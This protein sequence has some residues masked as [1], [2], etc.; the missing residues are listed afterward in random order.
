[1]KRTILC[2]LS[3]CMVVG[4]VS[5]AGNKK[6]RK[7]PDITKGDK[8]VMPLNKKSEG[9]PGY[10]NLGPTGLTGF[11]VGGDSGSQIIT[12][13]ISPHSPASGKLIRGDIILAG[14]LIYQVL[15]AHTEQ[16]KLMVSDAG[17]LEGILLSGIDEYTRRAYAE[18]LMGFI[19]K[20]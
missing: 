20:S 12:H 13:V 9:W 8:W 18:I 15:L 14:S 11:M 1:M 6:A 10:F 3:F 17:L 2:L 4:S 19:R 7:I 5:R 16:P